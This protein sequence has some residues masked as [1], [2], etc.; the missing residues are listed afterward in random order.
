MPDKKII[1]IV[2]DEE[3]LQN[4]IKIKLEQ[5]GFSTV[6]ARSADQ[7]LGYLNDMK[8][9]AVWLDHYLLGKKNGLDIVT[10]MKSDGKK[11]K[12]IPIFVVSN[13]AS[14]D[15]IQSYLKLGIEKYFTKAENSL[16]NIINDISKTID[17]KK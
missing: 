5:N 15:K 1:L 2:E 9:N 14:E 13:T 6:C 7:A 8:V 16:E 17:S 10:K 3:P 12:E 4:A 11:W